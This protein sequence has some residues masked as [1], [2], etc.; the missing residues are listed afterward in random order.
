MYREER[1]LIL[2][3]YLVDPGKDGEQDTVDDKIAASS[4]YPALDYRTAMMAPLLATLSVNQVEI[5]NA[6]AVRNIVFQVLDSNTIH[7]KKLVEDGV[8]SMNV[9]R[10]L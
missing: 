4:E 8:K 3:F 9:L 7:I 6:R 5:P 10:S 2:G 1:L